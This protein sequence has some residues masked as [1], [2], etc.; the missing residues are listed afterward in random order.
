MLDTSTQTY[1][2]ISYSADARNCT[3]ETVKGGQIAYTIVAA[4]D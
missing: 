1:E 3:V 2:Q 4:K